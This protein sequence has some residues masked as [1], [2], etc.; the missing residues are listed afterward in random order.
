MTLTIQKP[1]GA[2]VRT[3]TVDLINPGQ[4]KSVTIGDLGQVPF[5]QKTT[6]NVDVAPVPGEHNTANNKASY[7]VIF[8]LG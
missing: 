3:Q 2:I 8:S 1:Q 7:P 5:A 6:V 4:T